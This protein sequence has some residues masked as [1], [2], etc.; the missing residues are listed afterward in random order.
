MTW[1]D[2]YLGPT[3]VPDK[4]R[5][6]GNAL[7]YVNPVNAIGESMAASRRMM[8]PETDGW[9]RVEAAGDMLSGVAGVVAPGAIGA[10]YGVPAAQGVQDAMMGLAYAPATRAT[11]NAFADFARAE[12][13]AIRA[14][15][16]SPHDFDRFD[17]S[18]IGTGE[19]A[20]AYGHGLYFAENPDVARAYR[21]TI[22]KNQARGQGVSS[23]TAIAEAF[24]ASDL[25]D[26]SDI[27]ANF[28]R[29]VARSVADDDIELAAEIARMSPDEARRTMGRMYEVEINANPED[30]LDWDAPL[31]AQ[32][33]VA[34]RLGFAP[35]S[36]DAIQSEALRIMEAQPNG[37]WMN[38]PTAE[39]RINE[40]QEM[41]DRRAP[42]LTGQ[43]YY[44]GAQDDTAAGV[45]SQMTNRGF[46]DTAARLREAGIPG[47]RYL[48]AGSRGAG[49][50]SRNYVVF[51]DALI[52]ILRKYGLAGVAMGGLSQ[53]NPEENRNALRDYLGGT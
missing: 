23:R 5:A 2:Y 14:F 16:G 6:V 20:Q 38:N 15:H 45:L 11:G 50:G 7:N 41:L 46:E 13:G 24:Q 25:V 17:M 53:F 33:N 4:L 31:S 28:L 21:D 39:A 18:R 35:M 47:I 40:L 1:L 34:Q 29:S 8:A 44:R 22:T 37:A 19:G 51:D 32:P 52:N 30:F 9:G 3:G 10:R 43:E 27:D 26:T 48:D 42:S 49:D 12:D 36:E